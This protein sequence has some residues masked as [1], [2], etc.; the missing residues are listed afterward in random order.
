MYPFQMHLTFEDVEV[1][2]V[3]ANKPIPT[4]FPEFVVP[5]TSDPDA[6]RSNGLPDGARRGDN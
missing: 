1:R 6:R 5:A 3:Q 2:M 4:G